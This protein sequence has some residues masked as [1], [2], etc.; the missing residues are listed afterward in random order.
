MLKL[1]TKT[2]TFTPLLACFHRIL[3]RVWTAAASYLH[4][5]SKQWSSIL[6]KGRGHVCN[7]CYINVLRQ[8]PT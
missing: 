3:T 7:W 1:E 8:E 4:T 2:A 6:E 5:T